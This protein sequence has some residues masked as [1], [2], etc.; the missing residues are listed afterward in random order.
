MCRLVSLVSLQRLWGV[1]D[2]LYKSVPGERPLTAG[3][4]A[5]AGWRTGDC[6]ASQYFSPSLVGRRAWSSAASNINMQPRL[7]TKFEVHR[8]EAADHH[9]PASVS[10]DRPARPHPRPEFSSVR[11]ADHVTANNTIANYSKL[12]LGTSL[13]VCSLQ[14][15]LEKGGG[16]KLKMMWPS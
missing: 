9:P 12:R 2:K 13:A 16:K 5:G 10:W 1:R 3:G 7:D 6:E 14:S 15:N 4:E 11:G 8:S